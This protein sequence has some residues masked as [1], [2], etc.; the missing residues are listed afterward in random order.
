MIKVLFVCHGNICRSP[1]AEFAMKDLIRKKGTERFFQIDSAATT[2]E[3]IW[4]G[5]GNPVYPPAKEELLKH[6]IGT[7]ENELG[8]SAERARLMTA[9][10]YGTYDLLIGMDG[11]NIR[12]MKRIAGG[13]PE[14][15]LH[16]LLDFT[17]HPRNVADPWYTRNFTVTWHDIDEG[18]SALYA[19][20]EKKLPVS[21]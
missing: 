21:S 14:R 17:D 16:L 20:L 12:D 11:E 10:D 7:P 9:E 19:F 4:G 5:V 15:K 1:M 18:C 13:D 6:G 8:V 3:E 2:E